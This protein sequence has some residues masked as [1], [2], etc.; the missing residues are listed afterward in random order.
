[1]PSASGSSSDGLATVLGK[2]IGATRAAVRFDA[3]GAAGSPL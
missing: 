1:V 2:R 3:L